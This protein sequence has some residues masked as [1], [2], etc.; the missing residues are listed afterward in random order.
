M[1]KHLIAA[2]IVAIT[3]VPAH[4]AGL[5]GQASRSCQIP[6][7]VAVDAAKADKSSPFLGI[8]DGRW[9]RVL[10][11]TLIIYEVEGSKAYGYYAWKDYGP[12]KVKAGCRAVLG[13]ISGQTLSF[14]GDDHMTYVFKGNKP[15]GT[16]IYKPGTSEEFV[17]KASFSRKR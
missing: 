14:R 10:P 16:Y 4:A 8:F 3:S 17:E 6:Q 12:W 13:R 5:P 9:E 2:A 7:S 1:L 11:V 15:A